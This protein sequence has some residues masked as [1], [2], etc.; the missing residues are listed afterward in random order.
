MKKETRTLLAATGNQGK[1]KELRELLGDLPFELKSL[2]DFENVAEVAETGATFE[3][4][5]VLKAQGYARQT[6]VWALADDSGLEVAALGGEPGVYS[7]RYG[8]ENAP[9]NEKIELLLSEISA[10]DTENRAAQF[11]CVIAV[12]DETGAVKHLA[13]GICRGTIGFE[14]RGANGFGYDPI[15]IPDGFTETFGELSGEI[16]QKISHRAA[17][18][19]QIIGF[20]NNLT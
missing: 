20:L 10:C 18:S 16:K 11:V 4:N 3:E 5:A 8:G 15:F 9:F 1:I 2:N 17:A 7:A 19:A 6:G 13:K 14:P 12:A